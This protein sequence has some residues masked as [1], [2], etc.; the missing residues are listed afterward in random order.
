[1]E[2]Q[3]SAVKSIGGLFSCM[4]ASGMA[5]LTVNTPRYREEIV[6][7]GWRKSKETRLEIVASQILCEKTG[8]RFM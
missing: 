2:A 4:A 3:T 5:M 8:M 6:L 7:L 1:M